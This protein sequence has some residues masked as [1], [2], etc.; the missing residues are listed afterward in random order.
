MRTIVDPKVQETKDYVKYVL[1]EALKPRINTRENFVRVYVKEGTTQ[2]PKIKE[3][4]DD[5]S[6]RNHFEAD[7]T[8]P[9]QRRLAVLSA[10]LNFTDKLFPHTNNPLTPHTNLED[11]VEI[12]LFFDLE[13]IE[14]LRAKLEK[15]EIK[16]T[17]KTKERKLI[18]SA[19]KVDEK[20]VLFLNNL[21][22]LWREPKKKYCYSIEKDS[23]RHLIVKFLTENHGYHKSS[24]IADT[25]DGKN[26]LYVSKTIG[27]IRNMITKSLSVKG[28]SLIEYKEGSGYGISP[29]YKI[30]PRFS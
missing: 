20:I 23:D 15:G 22:E 17:P 1:S 9:Y 25:L 30:L 6:N 3:E 8:S 21:G 29:K 10:I 27:E 28:G 12:I 16:N 11:R 19:K 26:G 4:L 18:I 2:F 5:F 13:R 24:V 7:E 14:K